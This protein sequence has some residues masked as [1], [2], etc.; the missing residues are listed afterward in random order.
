MTDFAALL[1]NALGSAYQLDR[2]LPLGGLGRVY[3]ATEAATGRQVSVQALPPDLAARMD[4]GRFRAAVDRVSRLRHPGILPLI[5]AGAR[6][7]LLYCVWPHPRGE[8][9]RYRL[10]RDGGLGAEETVQVLHDVA[11]ALAYGHDNGVYHGDIRPDNIYLE[12]GRAVIAEFGIRS[13]LNAGLGSEGGMDARADV[14]ALAVAGQQMAAGRPGAVSAAIAR[15]VSIDPSEQFPSA[16][17]FR[18]AV[19]T[20]PS[21][22][23]RRRHARVAAAAIVAV[24]AATAVWRWAGSRTPLDPNLLAIAP[25]EILDSRHDVWREGLVTVLSANLDGAGPLHTVSPS[26]V[27]RDWRGR[28]DA[29]SAVALGRRTGA[30][31]ALFGRVV[32]AGLDTVRLTA[33]LVDVLSGA[34]LA[35]LQLTDAEA[36]LDRLADSLTVRLLRELSR[37]RPIGAVRSASLGTG[38]LPAL[39]LFLEGDQHYRRSE[40]DAALADY[41]RAIDID[42]AFAMALY[43]AGIVLGWQ[44]T[45]A[46]AISTAYLERAAAHNRG[47]PPRDSM[48]VVAESLTAA[49]E[50]GADDPRFWTL[51]RRL[52]RT[53][54]EAARR[55]PRDPEVWYE[56]GDVRYHWPAFSSL[57]EMRDA[58]DRS[59][60]LDSAFAPAFIHPI[61]LALQ[62]GDRAG[63]RRYVASYLALNPKDIYAD[64]VRLTAQLLDPARAR[65]PAVQSVLDTASIDLL[66]AALQSFRGWADSLATA[67]RLADL[68]D[69]RQRSRMGE[70]GGADAYLTALGSALAYHGRLRDAWR[71]SGAHSTWLYATTAWMGGV[72]RDTAAAA[73]ARSL[74]TDRFSPRAL[75]VVGAPWFA[76]ARDAASL[77]ELTRRADSTRRAARNPLERSFAR[78]V[79]DGARALGT[80]VRGDTAAAIR[81]L[82]AL[83]DTAACEHCALFAIQLAQLLDA[84]RQD[85]TAARVLAADS[86]GWIFPTDGLWE[87][88]RA[89][90]AA[91]RGDTRA[92]VISYE[93]VRDAWLGADSVLQPYVRE[94]RTALR[95][96]GKD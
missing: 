31:L 18:D 22:R 87:L 9:L 73:F 29:S 79:A 5:A 75:A 2:E 16:A 69:Q 74:R 36:R 49:L 10:I 1:Q 86:P 13:A 21:A 58:F 44:S 41:Q 70:R 80:L 61:E 26:V 90:L 92:E 23:R 3:L 91:R 25:F 71:R 59:I 57:R 67:V 94:A 83:P 78:Y 52:Y 72:P 63:A 95:R 30:R 27:V 42:S 20:P 47:L 82:L 43:R 40:W 8:S 64:G 14:H 51:Y 50:G 85:S 76:L 4:L 60:A 68:I 62:L 77:H 48:L 38:S 39:K 89:R 45:A 19:G 24:L 37:A 66:I 11:D 35:E 33:T 34:A 81:G 88:Y 7:D 54:S 96:R 56:F 53:T 6:E 46:D 65:G 28:A 55:F 93:F 12:A 17:A 32:R 15:A 84:R